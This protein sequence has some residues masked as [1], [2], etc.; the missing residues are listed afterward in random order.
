MTRVDLSSIELA[1]SETA[2]NINRD[3]VLEL[4]RSHQPI[5]R[6]ELARLSGLQRS[7][8]SLIT[9]QLIEER[10][11]REGAVARRPRGRRPTL[12]GLNEDLVVIAADIHPS[13][14]SVAVIDLNGCLLS[15]SLVPL[16]ADPAAA[17]D[18]LS[19]CILRLKDSFPRKSVEGIGISLPG[20]VDPASQRLIFAPNLRW[21]DFDIKSAIQERTGLL[22]ALE[23]AANAC[24]VAELWFGRMEGIRNAVLITISEGV[25]TA[26]FANGQLVTGQHGMAGEFGHTVLDPA[27]P[28][29]GCGSKGCW[30]T[31]ASCRAALQYHVDLAQPSQ[32]LTFHQ[33]LRLA[34]EGDRQAAEALRLQ[35]EAI[36]RGMRLILVGLSPEV[37]IVAGDV[38][39]A[40]DRFGPILEEHIA[41]LILAGTPPRLIPTLEGDVARLRGAA[42]LVLQGRS[43]GETA[44]DLSYGSPSQRTRKASAAQTLPTSRK[45][46]VELI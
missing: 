39:T 1:S 21:P 6:A 11:I 20:R 32:D 33:L 14:S 16:G 44:A 18:L 8:V 45:P 2:R 42:A 23:N 12:L 25:G 41:Q 36:G 30:E 31:F 22:V 35:A 29:C 40:W 15:R 19:D 4:I 9:E 28:P 10:W 7:T 34:E 37:I 38:T 5:S 13:Q 17:A 26:I 43:S 27:G 24:L 46:Y 3:I